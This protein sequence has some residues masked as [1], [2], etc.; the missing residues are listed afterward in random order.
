MVVLFGYL[1]LVLV[2]CVVICSSFVLYVI[3]FSDM[4][5]EGDMMVDFDVVLPVIVR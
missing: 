1:E 2:E 5:W 3:S 4:F